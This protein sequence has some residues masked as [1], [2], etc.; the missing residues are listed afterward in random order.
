[1]DY[2]KGVAFDHR[3]HFLVI[4]DK[5][6]EHVNIQKREVYFKFKIYSLNF[7]ILVRE[8]KFAN[9]AVFLYF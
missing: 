7:T 8:I 3:K 1:M 5:M 6:C 9:K 4:Y 2:F